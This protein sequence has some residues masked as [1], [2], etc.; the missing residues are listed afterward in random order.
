MRMH[1][2]LFRHEEEK[3]LRK[4]V[5]LHWRQLLLPFHPPCQPLRPPDVRQ[6]A[7]EGV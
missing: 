2:A 7:Y 4:C 6:R 3:W 5:F 1:W